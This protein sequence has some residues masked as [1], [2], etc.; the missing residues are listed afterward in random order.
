MLRLLVSTGEVSGDLQGSLLVKALHAEAERRGLAL[1]VVALGG[2]RMERAGAVLLANTTRMGAIG[3]L[4]AIPFVLPTLRLQR[5]LKRWFKGEPPD[6]VVLIDYMGPNVSLGLRLK[7]KFPHVPVTYYIAPQEWAFKFGTKGRTNLISF[8]NQ[9]LAIFQQEARFYRCRGAN[10]TYVGHPLLDT[11]GDVPSRQEARQLLGLSQEAPVLLL[12]PASRRQELRY[13]LPHIVDA[14]AHLQ[15]RDPTLQ[16]VVPA[17]LHGFESHLS[18]QLTQA[19]VRA[20]IIPAAESDRLKAALCA[21]AD[22]AIAKSGTVN[23]ELA[24]RGVP[25]VVV[26]R[27]SRATAFVARHILRFS[28]PHISPVNLVLGERLVPELLQEDLKAQ[29]IVAQALPLLESSGPARI[30]I[31]AGYDR[32]RLELGEPGVT[33]RAA[34]A[35]LDQVLEAKA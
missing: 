35:I 3:L 13:M 29:T 16:V 11:I 9:I 8:T 19:G 30:G 4:E 32:L 20:K 7:R 21:A 25:Q 1:E 31:L 23:L 15:Q 6:G 33:Q 27:V 5:R 18:L 14:A 22:L 34:C 17:G 2:E 12:M 24:L 26:Y 28:V 10:V